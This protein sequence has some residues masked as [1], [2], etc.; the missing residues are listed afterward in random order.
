ME[1]GKNSRIYLFFF[2]FEKNRIRKKIKKINISIK[3]SEVTFNKMKIF[4]FSLLDVLYGVIN[5]FLQE[6]EVI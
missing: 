5:Y 4:V 2:H 6:Q 3:I 1:V